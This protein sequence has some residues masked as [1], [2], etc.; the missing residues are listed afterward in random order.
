MSKFILRKNPSNKIFNLLLKRYLNII[1]SELLLKKT[2][3]VFSHKNANILIN[4]GV[5][6]GIDYVNHILDISN[7][8]TTGEREQVIENEF[9]I[10]SIFDITPSFENT[11]KKI[12]MVS[13]R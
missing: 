9:V 3:Y 7:L 2:D 10:D 6:S 5:Y 4:N 8:T 11:F 1:N 12:Q 13:S